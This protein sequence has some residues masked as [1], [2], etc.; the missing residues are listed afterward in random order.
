[1]DALQGMRDLLDTLGNLETDER[2]HTH[3]GTHD[4]EIDEHCTP[5]VGNPKSS[6]S[7]IYVL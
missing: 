3:D 1:M 5:P 2:R 4:A 6:R 7:S